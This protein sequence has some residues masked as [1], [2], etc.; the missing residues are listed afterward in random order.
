MTN[1]I[2]TVTNNI[3]HPGL[4][5]LIDSAERF[6]WEVNVIETTWRGFGT[7]LIETYNFLKQNP[8][9]ERF[10]FVDAHDV[11]VLGSPEEFHLHIPST[12]SIVV[13]CE[14]A[15]WPVEEL[16]IAYPSNDVGDWKYINS[17]LYYANSDSFIALFESSPPNYEDDDQEWF[18]RCYLSSNYDYNNYKYHIARDFNCILF[19]SYSHIAENDFDYMDGRLINLKIKT[20]PIFIHGNGATDMTLINQLL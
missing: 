20:L 19:Q 16:A 2:I 11:V 14:K 1:T 5:R 7:K 9:I 3:K 6:G 10:V 8:Q 15:C 12:P 18:T 4:K 13:S 17:G